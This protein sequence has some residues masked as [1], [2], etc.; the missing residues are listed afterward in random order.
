MVSCSSCLRKWVVCVK[1]PQSRSD[2]KNERDAWKHLHLYHK[3]II[4]K[5]KIIDN[6]DGINIEFF[7]RIS[8]PFT[9]RSNHHNEIETNVIMNRGEGEED[10]SKKQE[11]INQDSGSMLNQQSLKVPKLH[12]IGLVLQMVYG[13]CVNELSAKFFKNNKEEKGGAYFVGLSPFNLETLKD[14]ISKE[15]VWIHL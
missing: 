3:E 8:P 9:L 10:G 12:D 4:K 2:L 13:G 11:G 15:D 5:R 7:D 1:C 14:G 6:G